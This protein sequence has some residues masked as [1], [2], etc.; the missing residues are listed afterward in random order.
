MKMFVFVYRYCI[1]TYSGGPLF[2]RQCFDLCVCRGR[3]GGAFAIDG[4]EFECAGGGA[5]LHRLHMGRTQVIDAER[6]NDG[7]ADTGFDESGGGGAGWRLQQHGG[8]CEGC[9]EPGVY[10]APC[11][12]GRRGH[13][14]PL[15]GEI[16]QARLAVRWKTLRVIGQ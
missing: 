8:A 2:V 1:I 15:A 6:M 9:A 12:G 11:R 7:A 13:D 3:T 10:H 4:A 5:H 14:E 16:G